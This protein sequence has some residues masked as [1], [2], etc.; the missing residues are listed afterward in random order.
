MTKIQKQ[1]AASDTS[2]QA[3]IQALVQRGNAMAHGDFSAL[4]QP[5]N[6]AHAKAATDSPENTRENTREDTAAFE[7]LRRV[8][9]VMGEHL[10]QAQHDIHDYVTTAHMAQEN[11]R[12]RLARELHDETV[13]Q[14][15]ALGQSIER[16]Q[17]LIAQDAQQ[18]SERL[19]IVRG[20]TTALVQSLR[21]LI[22]NLRP[23]ALDELGLVAAV[24]LM[25]TRDAAEHKPAVKFIVRGYT[26]G[27]TRDYDRADDH[28]HGNEHDHIR[29]LDAAS[30]LTLFRIIQEAW[31]NIVKHAD[32][33]HVI[34][35]F[36][37]NK[38][39]L[40]ITLKDDGKGFAPETHAAPA[41]GNHWGLMGMR[42][43]A[44]QLNGQVNV[45][46]DPGQGTQVVIQVPYL[47]L[48]GRDPVCGMQVGPDGLTAEYH[49]TLYRFCSEAC[50]D[51]FRADPQHYLAAATA[52]TT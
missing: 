3:Q 9:D 19:K 7:S 18:A 10:R 42:E 15:I 16:A 25:V 21:G 5:L 26:R 34:I 40:V 35:T 11:E 44:G 33:T 8:M 28:D 39:Q 49:E 51:A 31:T 50:R 2:V 13:Q 6:P 38:H 20:Q 4:G 23:P 14:L 17:G 30:E 41:R 45:A 29:R 22:A 36:A 43:R 27:D 32:A 37:Y 47:G 48:A 12:G 1:P 52:Q 46:S 24:R